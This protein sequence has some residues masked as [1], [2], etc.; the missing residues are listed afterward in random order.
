MLSLGSNIGDRKK[1]LD[2]AIEVIR[3]N[4]AVSD[5]KCAS[6]YETEPVGY[7]DQPW[8]LNTCVSFATTMEPLELLDYVQGIEQDFHRERTIRWGPRTL[9]IDI[10]TYGDI[11]MN[12]KRLTLPHPRYKERAFVL[13]PMS[14]LTEI[15]VPIPDKKAVRRLEDG[16]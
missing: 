7:L 16:I 12:T 10:I 9:D 3:S 4:E 13:V 6:F 1:T 11:T 2:D 15:D 5:L 14:E 8:F